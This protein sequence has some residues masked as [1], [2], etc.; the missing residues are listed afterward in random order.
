MRRW[1]GVVAASAAALALVGVLG[2]AG[3]QQSATTTT[4]S[5]LITVNGAGESS[6]T[7][8]ASATTRATAYREALA[9]ALDDARA[10]AAFVA[11]RSGVALGALESVTE[12]TGSVLDGC[13][14]YALGQGVAEAKPL[15]AVRRP[16]TKRRKVA[17]RPTVTSSV[18]PVSSGSYRCQVFASVSVS[19]RLPD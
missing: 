1:I 17:A 15:P 4:P 18:A 12:Q 2:V 5:R 8:E 9:A 19:Y 10:K 16:K 11:Q 13:T 7:S 14:V 3:A 6:V